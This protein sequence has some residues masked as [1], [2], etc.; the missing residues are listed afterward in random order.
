M[1][2]LSDGNVGI[3]TTS[4]GVNLEVSGSGTVAKFVSA[5]TSVYLKLVNSGSGSFEG[6]GT[7]NDDLHLLTQ[8]VN[9]LIIVGG[10]GSTAGNVGIGTAAPTHP[11]QVNGAI[12]ML[13]KSA[14]PTE[15][16]E[17]ECVVWMSDG[18]GKGD[19]GDVL[20]ASKA[21]G[22]TKYATLFDHSAGS[23]W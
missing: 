15:P 3:G 6:I 1:R 17:G 14:D 8:N 13:E 2:I 11:L 12:S 18:T 20:I 5:T 19:D 4:P 23:A 10:T 7:I 21:G 9:R 22:T 16:V